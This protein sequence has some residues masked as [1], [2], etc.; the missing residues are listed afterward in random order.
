MA[1]ALAGGDPPGNF[2]RGLRSAVKLAR[3]D[4][5][6]PIPPG[7]SRAP[8]PRPAVPLFRRDARPGGAAL[9]PRYR[10]SVL[11]GEALHR[12][13]ASGGASPALGP[14]DRVRSLPARAG[15]PGAA[16]SGP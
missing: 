14:A 4:A 8:R 11:P 7:S 9:L 13:A 10:P 16:P 15:D 1:L 3:R 12:A 6:R 2:S 5:A